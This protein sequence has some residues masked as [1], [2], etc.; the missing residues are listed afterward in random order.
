MTPRTIHRLLA[1]FFSA[2]QLRCRAIDSIN[3][4]LHSLLE[5][6]LH[7]KRKGKYDRT[8][9]SKE[10]RLPQRLFLNEVK[11]ELEVIWLGHCVIVGAIG[12]GAPSY[13]F[14]SAH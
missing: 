6:V 12:Y 5:P 10:I 9:V 7:R 13:A 11:D 3:S 2:Y 4:L 1:S 8:G 14:C